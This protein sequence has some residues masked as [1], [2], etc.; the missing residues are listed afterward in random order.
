MGYGMVR[1]SMTAQ[2]DFQMTLEGK[3]K[4]WMEQD[5]KAAG[6]PLPAGRRVAYY[7]KE[8]IALRRGK[9]PVKVIA[10]Q[11]GFTRQAISRF[12]NKTIGKDYNKTIT[13]ELIAASLKNHKGGRARYAK[14]ERNNKLVEG[15]RAGKTSPQLG[16][17]FG[18]DQKRVREILQREIP[19]EEYLALVQKS[20]R[21]RLNKLAAKHD[22]RD[23]EII[24]RWRA[25]ETPKALGK[26]FNLC[27]QRISSIVSANA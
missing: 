1:S 17:E 24:K 18:I 25:G 2:R 4:F 12:L 19:E 27:Q 16:Q 10:E 8:I 23:A 26:A 3:K 5:T 14:V 20:H 6:R 7:A 13:Y 11:L 9:T 22:E 21:T 15:Y